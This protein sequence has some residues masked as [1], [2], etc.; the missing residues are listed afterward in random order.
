MQRNRELILFSSLQPQVIAIAFPIFIALCIPIRLYALPKIF[1]QDEL[2]LID[3]DPNTV[4]LWI[5]N[6]EDQ[7]AEPLLEGEG[8][9][10]EG[11][12]EVGGAEKG[13]IEAGPI[14]A[15]EE[16]KPAARRRV[17]RAKT[18]SCPSGALMFSEE[19]SVLGPQLRPQMVV[20]RNAGFNMFMDPTPT[21]DGSSTH[22]TDSLEGMDLAAT[23]ERPQRQRRARPSREE[24]RS[25]S[26]PVANMLFQVELVNQRPR[27]GSNARQSEAL[28]T[29]LE[30]DVGHSQHS[31]Q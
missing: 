23:S 20:G 6:R 13:D 10:K 25:L 17:K 5:A 28:P 22:T 2:I 18:V 14:P 1:T 16:A 15:A 31:S 26:A 11:K 12:E 7:E 29:L 3:S 8:E 30:A 19:P 24:R 21:F 4:K 9:T 27:S